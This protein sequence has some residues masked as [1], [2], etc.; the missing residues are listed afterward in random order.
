M[1]VK[2]TAEFANY[3]A[4]EIAARAVRKH[5]SGVTRIVLRDNS[6]GRWSDEYH[7]G[8]YPLAGVVSGNTFNA[9]GYPPSI[10]G[11]V[12]G[13]MFVSDYAGRQN[14]Y[15]PGYRRETSVE[16]EVADESTGEVE[17]YLINSGGLHVKAH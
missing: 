4:A 15:E 13:P 3:D 16:M 7:I 9:G 17:S 5:C 8:A 2:I 6:V 14:S 10:A 1:S 11:G 12:M